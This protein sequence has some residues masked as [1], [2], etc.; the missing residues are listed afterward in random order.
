MDRG[1]TAYLALMYGTGAT[2]L[3]G[4]HILVGLPS[5][6]YFDVVSYVR[7]SGMEFETETNAIE[8][9]EFSVDGVTITLKRLHIME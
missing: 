3:T 1:K 5:P 7:E 4:N 6:V 9:I 8:G 2:H